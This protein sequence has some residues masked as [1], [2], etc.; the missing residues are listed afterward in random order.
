MRKIPGKLLAE[1]WY[2]E[3]SGQRVLMIHGFVVNGPYLWPEDRSRDDLPERYLT[4]NSPF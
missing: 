1:V 4:G 2:L 3:E